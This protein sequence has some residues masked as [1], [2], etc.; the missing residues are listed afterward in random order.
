VKSILTD[1][2]MG[3]TSAVQ[4]AAWRD[5]ACSVIESLA[6]HAFRWNEPDYERFRQGLAESLELLRSQPSPSSVLIS[7]GTLSQRIEDYHQSARQMVD[8]SI[9]ELHSIIRVLMSSMDQVQDN[10]EDSACAL[11][12]IE[13]TIEKTTTAEELRI[14]K[15]R[16]RQAL[17]E[18]VRKTHER[19]QMA[20]QLMI[21]LQERV[22]ILEQSFVP[23]A[24]RLTGNSPASSLEQRVP[25]REARVARRA[26]GIAESFG[27]PGNPQSPH[28]THGRSSEQRSG[29]CHLS[30]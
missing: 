24:A 8:N 23:G 7:A 30:V 22:L 26:G 18:L 16:L 6:T 29:R 1:N 3:A 27:P 5:L 4:V 17:G 2:S 13:E 21:N 14:A 20:S 15:V 19:K 9:S 10:C 12:Q 28:S 11:H 25:A